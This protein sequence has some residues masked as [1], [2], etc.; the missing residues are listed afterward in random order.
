MG[1]IEQSFS[2]Q[3]GIPQPDATGHEELDETQRLTVHAEL[4]HFWPMS[5]PLVRT[6]QA[7]HQPH[8]QVLHHPVPDHIRW[9]HFPL[10]GQTILISPHL[11]SMPILPI[12]RTNLPRSINLWTTPRRPHFHRRLIGRHPSTATWQSLP[13]GSRIWQTTSI[14]LHSGQTK[15]RLSEWQTHHI[16]CGV[17]FS[18]YAQHPCSSDFPA[19]P[20]GLSKPLRNRRCLHTPVHSEIRACR[21]RSSLGQSGPCGILHQH[22]PRQICRILVHAFGLSLPKHECFR[23][24]SL[25]SL[26]GKI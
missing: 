19:H 17:T 3:K 20:S 18:S 23:Q 22:R 6:H 1:D 10:W 7:N 14:R 12:H 2:F 15:E 13:V 8:H 9:C 5:T 16:L 24:W 4:W 11:L 21:R 26:P 25:L